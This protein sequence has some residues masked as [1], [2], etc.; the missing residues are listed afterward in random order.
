MRTGTDRLL[1]FTYRSPTRHTVLTESKRGSGGRRW[2]NN[3]WGGLHMSFMRKYLRPAGDRGRLRLWAH[4]DRGYSGS[5][6]RVTSLRWLSDS[7]HCCPQH[8]VSGC[9]VVGRLAGGQLLLTSSQYQEIKHH[10]KQRCGR[11]MYIP[12]HPS[13]GSMSHPHENDHAPTEVGR[14]S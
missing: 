3:N 4:G 8:A 7:H 10:Q 6:K 11:G 12:D 2:G 9:P 14:R 5:S 1:A 13:R